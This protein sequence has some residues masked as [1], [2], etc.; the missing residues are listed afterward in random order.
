MLLGVNNGFLL[1]HQQ[2]AFAIGIFNFVVILTTSGADAG[3]FGWGCRS[4]SR[5]KGHRL[6]LG[7]ED[8]HCSGPDT[9]WEGVEV[10]W[11]WEW[12]WGGKLNV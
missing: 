10:E 4:R 11:E 7:V 6:K 12:E 2:V 1:L 5:E 3:R 8:R 9:I